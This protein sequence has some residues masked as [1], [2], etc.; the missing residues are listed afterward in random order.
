MANYPQGPTVSLLEPLSGATVGG[1]AVRLAARAT[2]DGRVDKVEFLVDGVV[3]ATD[4]A[5]PFEATWDSTTATKGTHQLIA[6]AT[7]DVGN[8]ADT[9]QAV[10]VIVDNTAGPTGS[11]TAPGAGAV[12]SGSAVPLSASATGNGDAVKQV[13]FLVDGDG[14]GV[15]DTTSPYSVAWNTLDPLAPAFDGD[16]QVQALITETSGQQFR[17][18]ATTVTVDNR[19]SRQYKAKLELNVSNTDPA[20]DGVVPQLMTESGSASLPLQDPYAGTTNPDGTSGGSLGRSITN[21]PNVD[22]TASSCP[23]DAYC[24]TVRITNQSGVAWKNSTGLDL[25]VWYRWY[26]PNGA[27]LLEG[28]ANDNFPNNFPA[29]AVKDFPLV[30][31]P[32]RLP[33][34]AELG[35]YRLRIDLYDVATASWYAGNGNAPI[36]RPILVA[37]SLDDKL[38]LERFWHYDGEAAGAGMATLTNVANGNMLLRWTPLFAPGRGLATM[39]DLTYN[40]LE[41]HSQSPAGNNFSLAISG[42]TRLGEPLDIHPNKADDVSNHSN[43]KFVE[44]VDG[45]GTTHRFVGVTQPD[46]STRWTEPAG[47]NLYLRSIDSNPDSRH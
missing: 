1:T 25:R 13:E 39:L 20:D 45:D 37:K 33:P 38:G 28:P 24:P 15:P 6:R 36:D 16:H 4:T 8:V 40:S 5:A 47:V 29:G 3:K 42:L 10:P 21:A 9:L 2:D 17:T 11:L 7:D 26:A 12:V 41:D 23:A 44:L 18:P 31:Q 35:V 19:A 30:I 34:G 22:A 46:G 32:P 43:N 27:I 14:V